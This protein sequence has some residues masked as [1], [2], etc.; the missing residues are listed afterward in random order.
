MNEIKDRHGRLIGPNEDLNGMDFD[1]ANLQGADLSGK[2]MEGADFSDANL[3]NSNLE[4]C[5]LYWAICFRTNLTNANL[6][7]AYFCGA[8]LKF[9][10]FAGADL[11]GANFGCDNLGGSTQLQ[12][13]NLQDCLI[14]E[15]IFKLATYDSETK[16]PKNF[17]PIAQEMVFVE[18]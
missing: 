10:N 8:D 6:K 9:A 5:D 1:S 17:D 7:R 14:D 11:R 3:T 13:A 15:A 4:G 2:I 18:M 12:G 16:F